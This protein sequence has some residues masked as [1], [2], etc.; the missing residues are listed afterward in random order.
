M[1]AHFPG[2][3]FMATQRNS[4]RP[5]QLA[6]SITSSIHGL[7][8]TPYCDQRGTVVD[9]QRCFFCTF[10]FAIRFTFLH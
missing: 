6:L 5:K 10:I 8:W 1:P 4:F 2:A 3:S 9:G 7:R